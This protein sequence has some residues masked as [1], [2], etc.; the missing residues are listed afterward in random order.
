M[1][2]LGTFYNQINPVNTTY[3]YNTIYIGDTIIS[4]Y[5]GENDVL[6]TYSLHKDNQAAWIQAAWVQ[7]ADGTKKR[8]LH[9]EW[10]I[11]D[12]YKEGEIRSSG[13]STFHKGIGVTWR[14]GGVSIP[15]ERMEVVYYNKAGNTWGTPV[16]IYNL[17]TVSTEPTIKNDLNLKI[18]PNPTNNLLNF[19]FKEPIDNAE[20]R[21]YSSIG[22]LMTTQNITN[23]DVQFEVSDWRSGVS[24]YGVYVEGVL[25]KQGQVSVQH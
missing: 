6:N 19:Q 1:R 8:A 21:I 22:Q 14:F 20:I 18:F 23:T 7:T 11:N 12:C 16:N 10:S 4:Y 25:V 17:F 13:S 5:I 9:Q 3:S 24:F 15:S 2:K